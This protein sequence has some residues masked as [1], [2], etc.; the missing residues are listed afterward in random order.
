MFA[1][2]LMDLCHLILQK[3]VFWILWVVAFIPVVGIA[4][5]PA[6][7]LFILSPQ[8]SDTEDI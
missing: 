7:C 6:S 4:F 8:V 2:G 5:V 1:I 3:I